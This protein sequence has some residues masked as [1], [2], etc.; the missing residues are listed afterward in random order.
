MKWTFGIIIETQHKNEIKYKKYLSDLDLDLEL[1][2]EDS[3]LFFLFFFSFL[4]FLRLSSS[5]E[6]EEDREVS[7]SEDEVSDMIYW[8]K[9]ERSTSGNLTDCHYTPPHFF[10]KFVNDLNL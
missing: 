2:E 8:I 1:S 10:N 6:L 7:S 5:E 3:S 9:K 4:F